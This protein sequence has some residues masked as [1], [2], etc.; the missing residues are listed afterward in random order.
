MTNM[1]SFPWTRLPTI[2]CLY[3]NHITL[4]SFTIFMLSLFY[5]R[6]NLCQVNRQ[7]FRRTSWWSLSLYG[8]FINHMWILKNSNDLL[9]NLKLRSF[10][11]VSSIKTLI[12]QLYIPP[13]RMTRNSANL[14]LLIDKTSSI[15]LYVKLKALASWIFLSFTNFWR[16]SD[17]Y[18]YKNKSLWLKICCV[19][20][21]FHIFFKQISKR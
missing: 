17:A 12:F 10:S 1:L 20:L 4:N 13:Y 18:E 9:D 2:S 19:R 11:Q 6:Q 5:C 8:V 7:F 14:E 16:N 21:Q 15:Y 3:V